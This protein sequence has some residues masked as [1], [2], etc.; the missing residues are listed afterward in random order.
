MVMA[1]PSI[2]LADVAFIALLTVQEEHQADFDVLAQRMVAAASENDGL[3]IYEFARTGERVYGYERYVDAEAHSR[4]EKIIAPFLE[5]LS[6]LASFE[7]IVT[8]SDLTEEHRASFQAIGAEIGEPI[9]S[10]AQG[11]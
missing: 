3:L 8:L 9:A 7:T 1:V 11:Q 2:T 5:D 4:H 6:A 10:A